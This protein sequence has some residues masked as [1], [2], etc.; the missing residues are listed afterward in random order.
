MHGQMEEWSF[1]EEKAYKL[2][3]NL[4]NMETRCKYEN[5]SRMKDGRSH[6]RRREIENERT[7]T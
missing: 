6:E 5:W 1:K 4:M 7:P 2:A 3:Y